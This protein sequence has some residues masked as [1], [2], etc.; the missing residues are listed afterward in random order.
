MR[1]LLLVLALV[2]TSASAQTRAFDS[3]QGKRAA[4]FDDVLNIK[5]IQGVTVSP[6]GRQV[7]YGIREWVSEQDKMESRTHLWKVPAD[8]SSAARQITFGDKGESQ[9]QFSPDGKFV[10]FVAS[11][12]SADAKA[13]VYLMSIDGGEAWKLTDAKESVISYSWAPDQ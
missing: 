2:V 8:G 11:R 9:G 10:S 4:T 12:G 3:V 1:N 13:Q 6:D 5:G 7:I